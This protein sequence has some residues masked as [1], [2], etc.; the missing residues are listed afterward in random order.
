MPRMHV[1]F[2][3]ALQSSQCLKLDNQMTTLVFQIDFCGKS[4]DCIGHIEP[5]SGRNREDKPVHFSGYCGYDGRI[6]IQKLSSAA[7]EYYWS[8][9]ERMRPGL[10]LFDYKERNRVP[11]EAGG[12]AE[13]SLKSYEFD[14]GVAIK[15]TS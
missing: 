13:G 11:K 7:E 12:L 4:Y 8:I 9:I 14:V 15:Q 1:T 2:H 6:D 5:N 3:D 10:N